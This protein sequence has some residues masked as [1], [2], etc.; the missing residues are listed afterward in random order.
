VTIGPKRHLGL[1][2]GAARPWTLDHNAAAAERHLP[3]LVSV[4]DGA[5][6][7]IV[8]ALRAHD[9]VE[10]LLHQ[11]GH[12]AEPDTHAQ[13]EQPLLR[14]AGQLAERDLDPLRQRVRAG[15][16]G[17]DLINKYLLHGGSSCLEV[18]FDR[19]ARSQPERTRR[20]D[21]RLNFYGLRDKLV[22]AIPVAQP[23]DGTASSPGALPARDS[24]RR[25]AVV[26]SQTAERHSCGD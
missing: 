7:R 10:L 4:P 20:E 13:R 8:L 16:R 21:R 5:A 19:R 12:D 24:G 25:H 17:H 23:S 1:A 11:L 3:S 18:D 22:S 14:G 6:L 2:V 9:L 26:R 15:R